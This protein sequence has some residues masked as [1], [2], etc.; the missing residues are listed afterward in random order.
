MATRVY[1]AVA[2]LCV[3]VDPTYRALFTENGGTG[4]GEGYALGLS[5]Q[6]VHSAG[7]CVEAVYQVAGVLRFPAR[8]PTFFQLEEDVEV[9]STS[10][11]VELS[12]S[13]GGSVEEIG[14]EPS[15][16]GAWVRLRG[17]YL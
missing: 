5:S 1:T 6:L 4:V 3:R 14:W 13:S 12:A 9:S 17:T 2:S 16:A 7:G 10:T 11:I 8:L 15:F